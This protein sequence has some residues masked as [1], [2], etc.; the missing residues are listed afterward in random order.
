[1]KTKVAFICDETN[2]F[3]VRSMVAELREAGYDVDVYPMSTNAYGFISSEHGIF[4]IHMDGFSS[5]SGKFLGALDHGELFAR[6]LL[7]VGHTGG[8][9]GIGGLVPG[10][11]A[12][13]LR[14]GAPVQI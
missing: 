8:E 5:D 3:L 13:L 14:Q 7:A 6:E 1:M 4:I 12:Q 10:W 2:H 9:T 11:Q